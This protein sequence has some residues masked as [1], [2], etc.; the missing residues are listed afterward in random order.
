MF[1]SNE[2]K[3]MIAEVNA[4]Y[5]HSIQSFLQEWEPDE[6][7]ICLILSQISDVTVQFFQSDKM[8]IVKNVFE[9]VEALLV[10]GDNTVKNAAATCFLENILHRVPQ[11]VSP[12][13]L[14]LVLG[15]QS[16]YYC[17]EWNKFTNVSVEGF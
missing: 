2:A 12:N 3:D 17:R 16:L 15:P 6:P 1:N 14:R 11:E 8:D 9:V 13:A 5:R 7:G 4:T 10:N